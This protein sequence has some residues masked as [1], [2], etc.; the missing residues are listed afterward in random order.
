MKREKPVKHSTIS[1]TVIHPEDQ[2]DWCGD[3]HPSSSEPLIF[4]QGDEGAGAGL[5]PYKEKYIETPG[6]GHQSGVI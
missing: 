4:N 3:V 6:K 1:N 5:S 2:I